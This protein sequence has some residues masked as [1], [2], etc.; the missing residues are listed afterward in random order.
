MENS[1]INLKLIGKG[2][3]KIYSKDKNRIV[4]LEI[5]SDKINN[6]ILKPNKEFS[7]NK[8][9]GKR[10]LENGYK[11]AESIDNGKIVKTV[12]GGICQV[13]STLNIAVKMANLKILEVHKHSKAVE[14]TTPEYEAA[15]AYPTLDYRFINNKDKNIIIKSV[16]NLNK[17]EV[18]VELYE[19]M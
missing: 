12:G 16:I 6:Y 10:T 17:M 14:Y 2:I 15:V 11:I 7:F 3:T 13:S 9:L 5:A 8:V 4:N 1:N 19:E 18:K